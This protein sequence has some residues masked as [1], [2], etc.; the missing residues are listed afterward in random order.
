MRPR[1]YKDGT[2]IVFP[3]KLVTENGDHLRQIAKYA[4]KAY[5]MHRHCQNDYG[6][7][8][9]GLSSTTF[10]ALK[11][12]QSGFDLIDRSTHSTRPSPRFRAR[13]MF[14]TILNLLGSI[15][16]TTPPQEKTREEILDEIV[17]ELAA[18]EAYTGRAE[19]T[20]RKFP[21][22]NLFMQ[23]IPSE[24]LMYTLWKLD[25]LSIWDRFMGRTELK[26]GY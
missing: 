23:N 11:R 19:I 12:N 9:S 16:T 3:Y 14:P 4:K 24:E 26:L 8:S 22:R 25:R 2:R 7:V 1:A 13:S 6:D 5:R 15:F 20:G 10:H 18:S 17:V 21:R